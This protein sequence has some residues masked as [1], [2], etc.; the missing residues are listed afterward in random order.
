M[1]TNKTAVE[2]N[3]I[4]MS[5]G[6]AIAALSGC[7]PSTQK[8]AANSLIQQ[9]NVPLTV[10]GAI[11]N[12]TLSTIPTRYQSIL[13][14]TYG[15]TLSRLDASGQVTATQP[16]VV[17]LSPATVSGNTYLSANFSSDGAVGHFGFASLM[18]MGLVAYPVQDTLYFSFTTAAQQSPQ[19]PNSIEESF[20]SVGLIIGLRS[21]GTQFDPAQSTIYFLD[22]GLSQ[23][24]DCSALASSVG[25]TNDLGK[26]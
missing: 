21:G 14:G 2:L 22:C 23:G 11:P 6:M 26:R 5:L 7:A 16:Y 24:V 13:M 3:K 1:S 19:V 15:G 25:F 4:L 8:L 17:T 18:N 9:L 20:L 12:A 10:P